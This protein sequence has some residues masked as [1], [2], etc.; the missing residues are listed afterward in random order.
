MVYDYR[1]V[2]INHRIKRDR[3]DDVLLI[4]FLPFKYPIFVTIDLQGVGALQYR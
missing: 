3:V 4:H 1:I 2:S